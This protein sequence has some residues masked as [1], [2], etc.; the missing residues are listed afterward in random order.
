MQEKVRIEQNNKLIPSRRKNHQL[1]INMWRSIPQKPDTKIVM[2]VVTFNNML[3]STKFIIF[4][5]KSMILRFSLCPRL[6]PLWP[7]Y[8]WIMLKNSAVNHGLKTV[9]RVPGAHSWIIMSKIERWV[10]HSRPIKTNLT[11]FKILLDFVNQIKSLCFVAN[12]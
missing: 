2:T 9:D 8:F 4:N 1:T 7:C 12:V 6:A 5:Q 10:K 11:S 3:H